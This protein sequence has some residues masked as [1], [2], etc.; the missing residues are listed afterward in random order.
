[1]PAFCL[2]GDLTPGVDPPHSNH[3]ENVTTLG[4][5]LWGEFWG[6][7]WYGRYTFTYC[8][9]WAQVFLMLHIKNVSFARA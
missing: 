7:D 9:L 3:G 5:L 2:D 8:F 6:H 1:M 4:V